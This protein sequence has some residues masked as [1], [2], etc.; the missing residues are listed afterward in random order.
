MACKHY[1]YCCFPASWLGNM[2]KHFVL[3]LWLVT[4]FNTPARAQPN[5][6]TPAK[7]QWYQVEV[8]IFRNDTPFESSPEKWPQ[9]IKRNFPEKLSTLQPPQ[10]DSQEAFVKLAPED[11]T[12]TQYFKEIERRDNANMLYHAAWRQPKISRNIALPLLIQSTALSPDGQYILEGTIKIGIQRYIHI[13][14]DLWLSDY[15]VKKK[16]PLDHWLNEFAPSPFAATDIDPAAAAT[17]PGSALPYKDNYE[18]DAPVYIAQHIARLQQSRRMKRDE[19]HYLDHPLFGVLVRTIRY[20]RPEVEIDEA[21][22]A[23]DNF[24]TNTSFQE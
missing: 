1:F 14:T 9:R 8:L 2:A 13:D 5:D 17:S 11:T 18:T 22:T 16:S 10:P 3:L 12:F 19:L 15:T 21:P 7:Q 24:D 6:S 23:D 4:V 20:E